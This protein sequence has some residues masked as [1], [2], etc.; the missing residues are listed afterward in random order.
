MAVQ[1]IL[2][3]QV[4]DGYYSWT[5]YGNNSTTTGAA[6]KNTT[7]EPVLT[8][9]TSAQIL[10]NSNMNGAIY[11]EPLDIGSQPAIAGQFA[12]NQPALITNPAPIGKWRT[13]YSSNLAATLPVLEEGK[14]KLTTATTMGT[15]M[16]YTTV[17][18]L[19]AGNTYRIL[20]VID[21]GPVGTLKIGATG[22]THWRETTE[23]N[24]RP[25]MQQLGGPVGT[26][27]GGMSW[28]NALNGMDIGQ[29]LNSAITT[30]A[31]YYQNFTAK[32]NVEVLQISFLASSPTNEPLIID[33][34]SI[35]AAPQAPAPT[36]SINPTTGAAAPTQPTLMQTFLDDGQV[37]VDLYK[38]E[39][40]P[41][42]LSVEILRV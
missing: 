15:A 16:A 9:N 37:I 35:V 12:S 34:V 13:S 41:L 23:M 29:P 5:A 24:G 42:N 38:D 11:G 6:P 30:Q 32:T 20:V 10:G 17:T 8:Q 3:P 14:L 33:D 19:Q 25:N 27:T 31:R 21:S 28:I 40:I 7:T 1:L 22:G 2:Y 4:Y 18:G 39:T 36:I 26:E